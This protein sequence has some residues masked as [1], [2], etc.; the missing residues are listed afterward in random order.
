MSEPNPDAAEPV[1]SGWRVTV[2][3]AMARL[4][5]P[6]RRWIW[7]QRRAVARMRRRRL[8]RR[9]DFSASRPAMFEMDRQLETLFHGR[10]GFF[11]EAGANDGYQQSNTYS[12][13]RI[14]GWR[15][16]LVEPV[17]EL[18]REARRERPAS[19]VVRAALVADGFEAS[20]VT[21][22]YGGLMTTVSDGA[23][24]AARAWVEAAHAVGQEEPEHEFT[25]PARTL[26]GLLDEISVTDV[27]LLS[28]DVEGYEVEVLDGLDFSR[29]AP[30][31]ILV[32]VGEDPD[33]RT[34]IE[35]RLAREGY[36]VHEQISPF[37]LLYARPQ[38]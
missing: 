13:E 2:V 11:I 9:G 20:S 16:L 12:L 3:R 30:A 5:A 17:P 34:R 35:S 4:P 31:F 14:H 21:L 1:V 7:R 23:S 19:T 15:G 27:D 33:R 25:A 6:A 29:H 22:R 36:R 8:E 10:A 28:L 26:S 38:A 32:E 37:D 24:D 18:H